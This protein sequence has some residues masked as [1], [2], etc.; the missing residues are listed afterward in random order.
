M[1]LHEKSENLQPIISSVSGNSIL[2]QY[3][4]VKYWILKMPFADG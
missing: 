1:L 2:C 4:E 3:I